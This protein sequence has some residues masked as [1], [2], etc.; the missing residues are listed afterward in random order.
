MIRPSNSSAEAAGEHT[1]S[2]LVH[3]V[4]SSVTT[5]TEGFTFCFP[6]SPDLVE[7]TS[8]LSKPCLP[9]CVD[10]NYVSNGNLVWIPHLISCLAS[11]RY[12]IYK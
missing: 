8:C 10:E 1:C 4:L 6:A 2:F 3:H 5:H 9:S 12:L 7:Y 11:W